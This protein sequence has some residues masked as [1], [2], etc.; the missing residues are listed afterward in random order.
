MPLRR[1]H[2]YHFREPAGSVESHSPFRLELDNTFVDC[3]EG[4]IAAFSH[5]C[6]W[7]EGGAPLADDHFPGFHP[8]AVILLYPEVFRLGVATVFTCT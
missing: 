4:V 5:P 6:T 2:T 7:S 3:E 8:L 1:R